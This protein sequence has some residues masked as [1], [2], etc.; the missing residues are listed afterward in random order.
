M[1]PT[2][3]FFMWAFLIVIVASE[4]ANTNSNLCYKTVE[5]DYTEIVPYGKNITKLFQN[6]NLSVPL[7]KVVS[8]AKKYYFDII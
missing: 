1:E 7:F 6:L 5:E 4:A 2:D 8:I 3:H